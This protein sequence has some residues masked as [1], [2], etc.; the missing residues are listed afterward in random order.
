MKTTTQLLSNKGNGIGTHFVGYITATRQ[1]LENTFGDCLYGSA[2]DK[3]QYEW[4]LDLLFQDR[5]IVATIYDWKEDSKLEMNQKY[6]W[7]VGGQSADAVAAVADLL[8]EAGFS[9]SHTSPFP[10]GN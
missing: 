2:D 5:F 9:F 4:S 8:L 7:H 10:A 1:E 6:R 3:V